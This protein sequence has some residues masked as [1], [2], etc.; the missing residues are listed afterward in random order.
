MGFRTPIYV[1][2]YNRIPN[3]THGDRNVPSY[4]H[5]VYISLGKKRNIYGATKMGSS[6]NVEWKQKDEKQTK[7]TIPILLGRENEYSE[8]ESKELFLHTKDLSKEFIIYFLIHL[9]YVL[10]FYLAVPK[11]SVQNLQYF[12]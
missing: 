10:I 7:S 2:N 9:V 12:K 8:Q 4:G 5:K 6:F 11:I 1:T 3:Y